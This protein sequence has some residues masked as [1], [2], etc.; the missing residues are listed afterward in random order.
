[1]RKLVLSRDYKSN[2]L[3]FA[4]DYLQWQLRYWRPVLF[5]GESKFRLTRCDGRLHV[6]RRPNERYSIATVQEVSRFGDGSVM[7]WGGITLEEK[8]D[9][10]VIPETLTAARY[11]DMVLSDHV[12]PAAYGIGS[13]FLF[14]QDNAR[15]HTAAITMDFP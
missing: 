5:T 13:K 11:V 8:T 4:R 7:V 14:M 6:Y 12:V 3:N 15:P 1:M 9:L 2:R 10:V